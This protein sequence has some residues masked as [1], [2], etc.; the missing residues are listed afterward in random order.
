LPGFAGGSKRKAVAEFEAAVRL[1]PRHT[2]NLTAL[3]RALLESGE[4]EKAK[5]ALRGAMAV[6]DPDDPAEHEESLAEAR[7]MLSG[8]ERGDR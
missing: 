2:V 1:S 5:D 3:G 4:K 6:K 7:R 8:I